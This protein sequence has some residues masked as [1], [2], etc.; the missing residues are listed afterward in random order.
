MLQG[1]RKVLILLAVLGVAFVAPGVPSSQDVDAGAFL[2]S[3]N[4]DAFAKLTVHRGR[5]DA[6][7]RAARSRPAAGRQCRKSA[8]GGCR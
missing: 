2:E 3:L 1:R 8:L 4:R 7:W 5:R 6:N